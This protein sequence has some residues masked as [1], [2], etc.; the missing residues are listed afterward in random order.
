M[1]LIL[2]IM[3]DSMQAANY[4]NIKSLLDLGCL[5]VANMI[6]GES[7]HH[8]LLPQPWNLHLASSLR[9]PCC[10]EASPVDGIPLCAKWQSLAC[11]PAGLVLRQAG[12]SDRI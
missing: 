5:T 10:M 1:E 2:D 9:D 12:V 3:L 11:W 6:K 4:L 7:Q 8:Q